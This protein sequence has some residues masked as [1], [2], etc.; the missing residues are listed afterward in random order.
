MTRMQA[1]ERQPAVVQACEVYAQ[2]QKVQQA[3][4]SELRSV[5][6]MRE[7]YN[8]AFISRFYYLS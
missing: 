4:L 2:A 8:R 7:D 6:S 3:A 1:I 5:D